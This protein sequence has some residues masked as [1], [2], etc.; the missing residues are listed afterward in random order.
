M[1]NKIRCYYTSLNYAEKDVERAWDRL[2]TLNIAHFI[3]LA[4][5]AH[6]DPPNFLNQASIPILQKIKTDERFA[7]K[8]FDSNLNVVV[9][10]RR[11][12]QPR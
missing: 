11:E 3:S 9:F 10:E 4:E 12:D 8:P 1:E 5:P 2:E 6:P 7:V